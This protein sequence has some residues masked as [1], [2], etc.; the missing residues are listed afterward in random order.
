MTPVKQTRN[1]SLYGDCLRACIASVL[2][3]P[4]I[5]VPN[6]M[7]FEHHWWSALIMWLGLHA[8]KVEYIES[9]PPKDENYYVTSLKFKRH[10][11]GISHAVVMHKGNVIHDPWN[12]INYDHKDSKIHGYYNLINP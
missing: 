10:G 1:D 4:L 3:K 9:E 12:N 8:L 6:F 11:K 7:L 5:D 2:D